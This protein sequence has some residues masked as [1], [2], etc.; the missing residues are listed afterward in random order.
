MASVTCSRS[1]SQHF[2]LC[3]GALAVAQDSPFGQNGP[4]PTGKQQAAPPKQPTKFPTWCASGTIRGGVS[5]SENRQ[6]A[7]WASAKATSTGSASSCT[8]M[9]SGRGMAIRRPAAAADSPRRS[10][11]ANASTRPHVGTKEF[12]YQGQVYLP[13][14]DIV[15]G[16]CRKLKPGE[17]AVGPH[18]YIPATPPPQ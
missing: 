16:C 1:S 18:G 6:R 3:A 12:S 7:R 15:N 4:A 10:R 13:E 2:Y 8:W 5:S 17:A 11:R 14:G 9:G